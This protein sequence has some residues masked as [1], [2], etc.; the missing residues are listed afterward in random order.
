MKNLILL[1]ALVSCTTAV[2]TPE[3]T[4]LPKE[5]TTPVSTT[6]P[7]IVVPSA[8]R[9]PQLAIPSDSGPA[10]REALAIFNEFAQSDDFYVYVRAK[11]KTLSGGNETNVERAITKTRECFSNLGK[12]DVRWRKYGIPPFYKSRA[13]G[14]W[15]NVQIN[16]N[17]KMVLTSIERAGHWYHEL[18]HACG[19]SHIDNDI[20]RSPIIRNSWPYQ[21]GYKFEDYVTERRRSGVQLAGE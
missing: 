20:V 14:G 21:A 6:L 12:I 5:P 4:T 17:P 10:F 19:F 9:V 8:M 1:I 16:Q 11:V 7:T 18:T 3:V 15:D 13:I 2:K